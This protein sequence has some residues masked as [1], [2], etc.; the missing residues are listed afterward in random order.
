MLIFPP[1]LQYHQGLR[2][3]TSWLCWLR[4]TSSSASTP[5]GVIIV[6][7]RTLGDTPKHGTP[8]RGTYPRRTVI[9]GAPMH[10]RP[11]ERVEYHRGRIS[12]QEIDAASHTSSTS[13][14]VKPRGRRSQKRWKL[15]VPSLAS[16][17]PLAINAAQMSSGWRSFASSTAQT[18]ECGPRATEQPDC[19]F[20]GWDVRVASLGKLPC[21]SSP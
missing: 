1:S 9:E 12:F 18:Q 3:V 7:Q 20:G 10:T 17:Y 16:V 11:G 2:H 4:H 19:L 5:I 13:P 14:V 21:R 6:R 15:S 8:R